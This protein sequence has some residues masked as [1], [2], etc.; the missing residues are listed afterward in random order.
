MTKKKRIK[1]L[2]NQVS[3]LQ[4]LFEAALVNSPEDVEVEEDV[5][6][7][8]CPACKGLSQRTDDEVS[9]RC[10][11]CSINFFF[12]E[13]VVVPQFDDALE[14]ASFYEREEERNEGVRRREEAYAYKNK[15]KHEGEKE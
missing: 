10:S 8:N 13:G 11:A 7:T 1:V 5:Q 14:I 6:F 2:M 3:M 9:Y 4:R 12:D 15:R